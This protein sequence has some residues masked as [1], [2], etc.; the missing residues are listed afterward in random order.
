MDKEKTLSLRIIRFWCS[1]S[2]VEEIEGNLIEFKS[3]QQKGFIN[4]IKYWME[5]LGYIRLSTMKNLFK[6]PSRRPNILFNPKLA[7]R[8]LF[9]HKTSALINVSGFTLGMICMLF[10]FFYVADE[11]SYDTFHQ[12]R[13]KIYRAIRTAELNGTPYKI[14]VTSG[15]FGPALVQDFEGTIHSMCR[16]FP[17][18]GLVTVGEKKF[19]EEEIIYADDNF[20]QFFTFELVSGN[21][22]HVLSLPN[23][24]VISELLATK[25]FPGQNP[26]NK[27]IN[28]NVDNSYI[29]TGVFRD[30]TNKRTHMKF[31]MVASLGFYESASWFD[32]WW[33]NGLIT[34]VK[35]D[36]PN[37]AQVV[38][39][40]LDGFMEKYFGDDFKQTGSKIGL[41]LESISETYFNNDTRY[42]FVRHGDWPTLRVLIMVGFAI[43]FIAS[44][45]FI[46]LSIAFSF[47][48]S[49]EV[50]IR[51][52]L[53]VEK[54]RLV[55]Q[56]MGES[57]IVLFFS[58]VIS[59]ILCQLLLPIINNFFDLDVRLNW[60]D[61]GVWVF[62]SSLY[63][64]IL[65]FSSLYPSLM[66]ASFKPLSVLN[67][68][69][70]SVGK[71][72][73]LRRL[74]VVTQFAISIFLI[75]ATFFIVT[76]IKYVQG[77]DVGF[78]KEAVLIINNSNSDIRA[79]L[80]QF[81]T[82]LLINP[83]I[84]SV[85][86]MTGEPG[87]FHDAT[88]VDVPGLD[89]MIR[90]RTVFTDYNYLSTL[91]ISLSAGEN[92]NE[93]MT[94]WEDASIIFNQAAL[95]EMGLSPEELLYKTVDL[96]SW[97][98]Q[99][100]VVGISTNY[101]FTSLKEKIEPLVIV[102]S[103]RHHRRYA[104]SLNSANLSDGIEY[105]SEVW[106]KF[107]P[108]YP[109]KYKFLDDSLNELYENEI[110]QSK[111]FITFSGVSILLACLGILG[112]ASYIAQ[113]R[114]KELGIRKVLG[115]SVLQLIALI[116]KQFLISVFFAM[117][118]AT[119]FCYF[120]VKQWLE[121]FAYRI[122]LLNHLDL[123]VLGGIIAAL[124]AVVT[125]SARTYRSAI[126]NPTSSLKY[127]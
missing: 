2:L 123:F 23:N 36:S 15:P 110:K 5:V 74:L 117:V 108:E 86:S 91:G 103:N 12:E 9:S 20:F 62:L 122:D 125:I 33:N 89:E 30:L 100:K 16:Y 81:K 21:P 126:S 64:I 63:F 115:A 70:P 88:V 31:D 47:K 102:L 3:Q 39:D 61:P 111:V 45:N 98:V 127:E 53:G 106:Q 69:L 87:G 8:V 72:F 92:F 68:R 26:I 121:S 101:N 90:V 114:Q 97:E 25:Y 71:G 120:F 65:I 44:F 35:I 104:I 42:D 29:V 28:I 84:N 19:A 54:S 112:L 58:F 57:A 4:S 18:N 51:K 124:V 60:L 27:T 113:R 13:D 116:G 6:G 78:N 48:R 11:M 59:M 38:A 107:S 105:V 75:S 49:K 66:M 67:G 37:E 118:V 96:P 109:I 95:E 32:G 50:G 24:V 40:Q 93:N 99:G 82:D 22:Q 55:T 80:D 85:T 1:S 76:Q 43:L 10:L 77:L 14:G 119:P 46:N 83:N 17:N 34:Y 52:V 79:N 7:V 73:G 94:S 56:F 41:T